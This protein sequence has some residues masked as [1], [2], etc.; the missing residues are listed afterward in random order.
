MS[1]VVAEILGTVRTRLRGAL[2]TPWW[3]GATKKF[4]TGASIFQISVVEIHDLRT[5]AATYC[6]GRSERRWVLY[7]EKQG[8]PGARGRTGGGAALF[9]C[10]NA[11]LFLSRNR[12]LLEIE[13]RAIGFSKNEREDSSHRV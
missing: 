1:G 5:S 8:G 6:K 13:P 10:G 11:Q 3:C 9:S 4:R 2:E 12:E 7:R